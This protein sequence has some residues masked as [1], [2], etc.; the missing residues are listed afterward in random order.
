VY[1]AEAQNNQFAENAGFPS[2]G[3]DR[4]NYRNSYALSSND[5]PHRFVGTWV[6]AMPF[7]KARRWSSGSGV[8]NAILGGWNVGGVL[9]AQSGQPQ[10]GFLGP[11]AGSL[12]GVR[13]RLPGVPIEVPKELQRWYTSPNPAERTV[14]LPSGRQVIVCR[15]CF[16]KYS[17]DAV[18]GRVVQFPN[19]TIGLDPYWFGTASMRYNDVRGFGRFNVNMSVQKEF[20]LR[21][22][23]RLQFSAEASNVLNSTQ[24]RPNVSGVAST[25]GTF[26]NLTAA[27]RAQGIQPG[28]IQNENFGTIDMGTFDPRQI[29]LRIRIFF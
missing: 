13:D 12:T 18:R 8:V 9:V 17:S 15:N 4:R 20:A 29:E 1:H 14:T 26:T 23:L 6:W 5:I 22:K 10:Q 27:Q 21:E 19:G 16:L 3:L 7:G 28:M 2:G 24:F 11:Q 25:G